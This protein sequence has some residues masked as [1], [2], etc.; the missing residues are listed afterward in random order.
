MQ[1]YGSRQR[2]A[3][4]ARLEREEQRR[5]KEQARQEKEYAKLSQQEQARLEV[6]EDERRIVGLYSIHTICAAD[7]DWLQLASALCPICPSVFAKEVRQVWRSRRVSKPL[8]PPPML[9]DIILSR[10]DHPEKLVFEEN[11]KEW[12][13]RK[14]LAE[15]VLA[16]DEDAYGDALDEFSLLHEVAKLGL[17]I[18]FIV[19]APGR[20]QVVVKSNSSEAIPADYKVLTASGK[21]SVKAQPKAR[22][23]EIYQDHVCSGLLRVARELFAVLPIDTLLIHAHVPI[24]DL[25]AGKELTK[26]IYSALIPR[27]GLGRLNFQHLDPS[28]AIESFQHRGDFKASRKARAFQP[29]TPLTFGD[30]SIAGDGSPSLDDL[31]GQVASLREAI[32]S[33]LNPAG[34]K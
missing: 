1:H 34:A 23:Q 20:V 31:R 13:D 6:Q 2:A 17:S 30:L 5:Q 19:H 18:E 3:S 7:V 32:D 28:N 10:P 8:V 4:Y 33:I 27:S 14:S 9:P 11:Y 24:Y 15:K 29:I 26:P 12:M 25:T 22:F 21:V 16:G